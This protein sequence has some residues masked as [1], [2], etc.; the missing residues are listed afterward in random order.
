[1]H[2]GTPP[3]KRKTTPEVQRGAEEGGPERRGGD[4][5][6]ATWCQQ[7]GQESNS[8]VPTRDCSCRPSLPCRWY[9]MGTPVLERAELGTNP[10]RE[11]KA[12]LPWFTSSTH[13]IPQLCPPLLPQLFPTDTAALGLGRCQLGVVEFS[14]P[15]NE[16]AEGAGWRHRVRRG[17]LADRAETC[18]RYHSRP[19]PGGWGWVVNPSPPSASHSLCALPRMVCTGRALLFSPSHIDVFQI[20][21]NE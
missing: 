13:P 3:L 16:Q 19:C 4:F 20:K 9:V 2:L 12:F 8:W 1:M 5:R 14:P 17:R 18:L 10:E 21:M 11:R 7:W 6:E 15:G